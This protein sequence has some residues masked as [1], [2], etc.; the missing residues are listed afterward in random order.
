MFFL[1]LLTCCDNSFLE[2]NNKV[3]KETEILDL[4]DT[5]MAQYKKGDIESAIKTYTSAI[6]LDADNSD[7]Y[8]KRGELKIKAG[9]S[10][11]ALEDINKALKLNK[12]KWLYTGGWLYAT[13]SRIKREMLR[14]Y[15]G[16]L[17]DI[18]KALKTIQ[19]GYVY[20]QRGIIKREL[21]DCEG[22]VEDINRALEFVQ[23]EDFYLERAVTYEKQKNFELA[24]NDYKKVLE[25]SPDK[26]WIEENIKKLE[27]KNKS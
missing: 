1:N 14:D 7:L 27:S 21:G 23:E 24:L 15:K 17:E 25:L 4:C 11:G 3:N 2:S 9:D 13:R 20:E 12:N 8:A 10:E 5:A 22:A 6:M 19:E 26:Y 16:A 18:N